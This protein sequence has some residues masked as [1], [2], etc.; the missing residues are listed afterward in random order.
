MLICM[1][2][3]IKAVFLISSDLQCRVARQRGAFIVC[4]N[5]HQNGATC[6]HSGDRHRASWPTPR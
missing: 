3:S 5:Y 4:L 6:E 2:R 1:L